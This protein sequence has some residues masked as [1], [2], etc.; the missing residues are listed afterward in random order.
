MAFGIKRHELKRWQQ[1]VMNG[2]IAFL[3]HYWQ[4][5]RFPGC[6]TVTKVGCIDIDKLAYWGRQYD[7]KTEWIHRRHMYPHFDL[8][9]KHQKDILEREG[10]ENHLIRFNL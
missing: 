7:L 3:T 9:G 2:D 4:D 1:Q 8:F 6:Y 10:L 5:V